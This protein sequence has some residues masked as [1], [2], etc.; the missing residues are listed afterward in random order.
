M[1]N[2]FQKVALVTGSAQRIGRYLV[3]KLAND[4][5][6][7]ALHYNS[8]E[9]Q[10]YELANS[11]LNLTN[12]ML[13]K[14]DLTNLNETEKLI[15]SIKTQLGDVSLL[16]NNASIYKNDDIDNL[17]AADLQNNLNIHLNSPLF[18]AQAILKQKIEANIINIL[19][20]DI[21][22]NMKKFFSYSLSKKSLLSLT[23]M[24]AVSLAPNIKVNAIA[25]GPTLF[26][27]GQNLEL[28]NKL[29]EESPLKN[30][31]NL[32][33]LYNTVDF[34]IKSQAITGQ[35]IFLDGGRHLL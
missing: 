5:W 28:F 16:I 8:S 21:T 24:L 27:E 19:D 11:L 33:E 3:E 34:L 20:S 9:A 29:I 10:A 1:F 13:F 22:Q 32:E 26:K 6:H 25:L 15:Q 7:I 2:Q 4:G 31:V 35:T 12:V 23:Q 17:N 18:L 14:A 30:K